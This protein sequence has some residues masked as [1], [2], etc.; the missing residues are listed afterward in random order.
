M[1]L[2]ITAIITLIQVLLTILGYL[3]FSLK[4]Y[5]F[6]FGSVISIVNFWVLAF[7]W[8]IIFYKKRVAPSFGIVVI[9]YGI[10][11]LIFS[12]IPSFNWINQNQMVFG[13]LLSP[14]ALVIGGLIIQKIISKKD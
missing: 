10:L 9:K 2:K 14:L 12:K 1:T 5:S 4:G 13:I 11:V 6:L 7:L 3:A 8:H